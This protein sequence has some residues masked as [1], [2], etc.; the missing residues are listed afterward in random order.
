MLHVVLTRFNVLTAV[1][2]ATD[3]VALDWLRARLD[4]FETY[5]LPSMQAQSGRCTWLVF[6]DARTPDEVRERIEVHSGYSP[7]WVDGVLDDA[8]VVQYV[9]ELLPQGWDTLVTTRLDNDDGVAVDFLARIQQEAAGRDGVFLNFPFGYQCV[10]GRLYYY[11]HLA[12]PFLSFVERRDPEGHEQVPIT[13]MSGNHDQVRRTKRLRQVWSPPMWL[14]VI[15]G[16]NV[17]NELVGIRRP[18]ARAP[19]RFSAMPIAT[20]TWAQRQLGVAGSVAHL[21]ALAWQRRARLRQ[22]LVARLDRE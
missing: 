3:V 21:T 19:V 5:C 6:F 7:V 13:V 12:N 15:H 17:I 4:L 8:R 18:I 11:V 16:G 22:R 20:E 9:A 14:Q 10:S 2:G 1:T